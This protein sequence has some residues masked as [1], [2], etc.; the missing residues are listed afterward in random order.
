[1]S[2]I[3]DIMQKIIRMFDATDENVKAMWNELSGIGHKVD[4]HVVSI[5]HIE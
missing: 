5:N 4:T 3:E 2:C 1:M